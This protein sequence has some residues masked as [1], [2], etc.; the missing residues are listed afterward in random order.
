M[1]KKEQNQSPK[2]VNPYM[3]FLGS[4]LI[5]LLLNGL[6]MP[7][8]S[9]NQIVPTD[10]GTFIEKVDSGMVKEVAFKSNQIYFNVSSTNCK[11]L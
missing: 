3:G 6:I 7:K 5:L 11:C 2:R 10:Y 9:G 1:I 8:L 4:I